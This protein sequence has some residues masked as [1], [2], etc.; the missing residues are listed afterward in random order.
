MS[1]AHSRPA[2]P[3]T[4]RVEFL[5]REWI[6][7]YAKFLRERVAQ[8]GSGLD[9]VTL[10]FGDTAR[11]A[12][13]HLN[14]PGNVAGFSARIDGGKVE[15]TKGPSTGTL[16]LSNDTDYN[17]ILPIAWA[18][19][20]ADP[21]VRARAQ[22][23]GAYLAG[24]K[25][26]VSHGKLPTH[27]LLLKIL[28]DSHNHM[29]LRT[30]NNPDVASRIESYGLTQNAAD[31]ADQGYT[32][33]ENA[34]TA[35]FASELR[36]DALR[37]HASQP[38]ESGFRGAMLLQRGRLWEEAAVHPWVLTLAEHLLGR[39]CILG[40]SDTILK[41]PGLDTHP[42]LHSDYA[43]WGVEY[44]F[45]D[46]CLEAT[47]VWAIDDFTAENG[48][49]CLLP[50]SW[51]KRSQV[52]KGT[53]QEGT[54]LIEMPKGSI[55]FWHGA[56]WHG[57]TV[58]TAPGT[59]V[60]LHNAYLRNYMRPVERYDNLAQEIIDRNA[61]V[62]STLCG[63]DDPFGK[64]TNLGADFERYDYAIKARFGKSGPLEAR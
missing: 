39:G 20:G 37:N 64:S 50:G 22:R 3:L 28:L 48:P 34:F 38:P 5:S 18:V 55:A 33:I 41:G 25:K 21:S 54:V 36:E 52:P 4:E 47:A 42:G 9:G 46:Q 24:A 61:P 31:L 10:S 1:S 27:P 11:N 12:P 13:P 14:W 51:R 53:T 30:V 23:E 7:S 8:A 63:V 2:A 40:Q 32:V 57:A 44:P 43:I 58:R 62:F 56:S 60:S 35:D 17:S 49:T 29:A 19:Y 26:A 16:D 59:R 45:P 6:D 15:V